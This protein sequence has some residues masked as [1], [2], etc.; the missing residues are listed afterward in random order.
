MI[1]RILDWGG[2]AG[3]ALLA[4]GAILPFARPEWAHYRGFL[5]VAGAL[6]VL[7]W[8]LASVLWWRRRLPGLL[9]RRNPH[10][11]S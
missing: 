2:Y 11:W 5:L 7:A 4:A 8:L 9:R 6:L 10:H 3:L 1:R